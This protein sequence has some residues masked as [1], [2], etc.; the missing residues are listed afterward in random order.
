MINLWLRH[1]SLTGS[2]ETNTRMTSSKDSLRHTFGYLDSHLVP[3]V[4]AVNEQRALRLVTSLVL[5]SYALLGQGGLLTTLTASLLVIVCYAV[6]QFLLSLLEARLQPRQWLSILITGLDLLL[7]GWQLGNDPLNSLPTIMLSILMTGLAA[8]RWPPSTSWLM[9]PG[10]AGIAAM[11]IIWRA[12]HATAVAWPVLISSA[13]ACLI[14]TSLVLV[15]AQLA[16]QYLH[17]SLNAP[18]RDPAT[19]LF[20]R[21]TLYSAAEL[22][23][24]LM[25]RQHQPLTLLYIV[26]EPT[27]L[28]P[29]R[30]AGPALQDDLCREFADIARARLRGSDI[31]VR[32]SALEFVFLLLDCPSKQADPIAHHLQESFH[33]S[34]ASQQ[35]PATAHIGATWLPSEPMA[36]DQL[37]DHLDEAMARA[38]RS[39]IG[40]SGAIYSDPEQARTGHQLSGK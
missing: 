30:E 31:L 20:N 29:G 28:T 7:L 33:A 1:A 11:V 18:G 22:L 36:L 32:Y 40:V 27:G 4:M 38:R 5:A 2:P 15:I 14:L 9:M 19:G 25:H 39:R 8:L 23:M 35:S 10:V 13:V 26:L 24:P 3:S 6:L 37:L 17:A 16:R 12:N 34:R 21:P